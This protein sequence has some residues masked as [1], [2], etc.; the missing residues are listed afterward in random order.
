[1]KKLLFYFLIIFTFLF[2]FNCK[3]NKNAEDNNLTKD[4]DDSYKEKIKNGL[5]NPDDDF[6]NDSINNVYYNFRYKFSFKYP[7]NWKID[8]GITK[9]TV[10]NATQI[11]S[12][13]SFKV[14][15]IELIKDSETYNGQDD[16]YNKEGDLEKT[17]SIIKKNLEE[18]TKI[19]LTNFKLEKSHIKNH[20][21]FKTT[22]NYII[23]DTEYEY[24]FKGIIYNYWRAPYNYTI[25]LNL[26]LEFYEENELY[27][28][29]L[30]SNYYPTN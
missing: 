29:S 20:K 26:P 22:F 5:I 7:I 25:S 6:F 19:D 3:E 16:L 4:F 14:I 18:L 2:L 15:A 8:S 11:D 28:N 13:I 10:F 21:S 24:D 30:F 1:M 23:K 17:K 9:N 12:G 27:Y